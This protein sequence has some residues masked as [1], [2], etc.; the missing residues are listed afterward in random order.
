M[1]VDR[2]VSAAALMCL[3]LVSPHARGEGVASNQTLDLAKGSSVWI[4]GDSTL[5]KYRLDA[6]ELQIVPR[7]DIAGGPAGASLESLA[8]A[9]GLKSLDVD[10]GVRGLSSGEGGLDD[11]MRKALSADQYHEIRFQMDSYQSSPGSTA[12]SLDLKLKGRLQIAAVE[13]PI[14]LDAV[15]VTDGQVLHVTGTKQ[16]LMTDYGVKPPKFML[17]VM[18][19]SDPITVHFDL[20]LARTP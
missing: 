3:V 9:G 1:R 12:G 5:H 4:N 6:K 20:R 16:L 7:I 17:G 18:S 19:V 14:E 10:V 11:N 8:A 2:T 13:K 15:G